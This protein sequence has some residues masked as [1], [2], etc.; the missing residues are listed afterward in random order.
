MVQAN[1]ERP[2]KH[3]GK[4]EAEGF[5]VDRPIRLEQLGVDGKTKR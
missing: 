2:L 4:E 5:E 3:G 1:E